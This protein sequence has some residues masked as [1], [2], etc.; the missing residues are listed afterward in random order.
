MSFATAVASDPLMTPDQPIEAAMR[1]RP[2]LLER[3][4]KQKL[5]LLTGAD[6]MVQLEPLSRL[7]GADLRAAR[8]GDQAHWSAKWLAQGA[9][10]RLPCIIDAALIDVPRGFIEIDGDGQSIPL[11]EESWRGWCDGARIAE[12]SLPVDELEAAYLHAEQ[13]RIEAEREEDGGESF[14]A[15]RI[16]ARL[17]ETLSIPPLSEVAR[18]LIQLQANPDATGED[19]ARIVEC[20]ASLAAQVVGWAS[21]P[22]YGKRGGVR[23][24]REAIIRVLG[25]DLVLNLAIGLAMKRS[26]GQPQDAPQGLTSYARQSIYLAASTAL[27][28][29]MMP[30]NQRPTYG[31]AYL[32]GLLHNYGHLLLGC[33]FPP[34]FSLICRHQELNP[35]LPRHWME[36]QLLGVTR[37]QISCWMFR[38]WSLPDEVVSAIQSQ[39]GGWGESRHACLGQ[40]L[41]LCS[42]LLRQRG[43]GDLPCDLIDPQLYVALQIDEAEVALRLDELIENS[44]TLDQ[45]AQSLGR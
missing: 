36:Q 42:R 6:R 1:L 20:D 44:E 11:S 22:F 9:D 43:V 28:S 3:G 13:A 45:L 19:L 35:R 23:T 14:S 26:L 17:S 33:L 15:Q 8:P 34:H 18:R 24:V 2:L 27:L 39:H 31:A 41:Y 21:S 10:D 4:G 12:V 29:T 40:L 32:C 30:R 25:F 37:E 5:M 16:R 38:Q 7:L